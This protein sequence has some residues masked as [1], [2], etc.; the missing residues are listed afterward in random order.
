MLDQEGDVY[1]GRNSRAFRALHRGGSRA[2]TTVE[3]TPLIPPHFSERVCPSLTR[4]YPVSG[5][6]LEEGSVHPNSV[7]SLQAHE[8]SQDLLVTHS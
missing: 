7:S 4:L 8:E 6:T 5:P 1:F 3:A 2:S